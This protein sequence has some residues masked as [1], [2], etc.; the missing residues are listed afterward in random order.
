MEDKLSS[1][2]DLK[3]ELGTKVLEHINVLFLDISSSCTGYSVAKINFGNKNVEWK[4]SGVLW[5]DGKWS[6]QEKYSYMFH[7]IVDYFWIVEAVDYI[8]VE[9]YSVNPKK[10]MGVNV[11]SEMQ[12]SIKVAAQENNVKVSSILPQQWRS[13]LKIKADVK[14]DLI[15]NKIIEKD[16]KEPTKKKVCSYV[17]VPEE[18]VSNITGVTR[19]TPSDLYDVLA[20]GIA[21]LMKLGF[22][23]DKMKFDKLKFNTHIGYSIGKVN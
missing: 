18:S 12:G 21:W 7:A 1:I 11:V 15:T 6:H 23:E 13:I 22:P 16:Y 14:R 17:S 9:Q 10:M 5:L 20:I 8:V 2:E 3:Q 4:T 19:Q